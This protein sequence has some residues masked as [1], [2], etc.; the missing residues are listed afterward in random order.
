[1][2][3]QKITCPQ[4]QSENTVRSLCKQKDESMEEQIVVADMITRDVDTNEE[5]NM[6][7]KNV[8]RI[9]QCHNCM[10][11]FA[12]MEIGKTELKSTLIP[13]KSNPF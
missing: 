1:M 9:F 7:M 13:A 3:S 5:K 12:L 10:K 6:D 11:F 8:F 2:S 4:C